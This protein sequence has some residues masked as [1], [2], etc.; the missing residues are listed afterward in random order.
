VI[1]VSGEAIL[2][3]NAAQEELVDVTN[4]WLGNVQARLVAVS[5]ARAAARRAA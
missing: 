1:S 2:D 4:G 3:D 5:T